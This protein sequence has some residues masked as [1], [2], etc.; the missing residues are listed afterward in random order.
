MITNGFVLGAVNRPNAA[1]RRMA[2]IKQAVQGTEAISKLTAALN[3]PAPLVR[4]AA[5]RELATIGKPAK[6]ALIQ[7]L[8]NSDILVRRI[9]TTALGRFSGPT[10]IKHLGAMLNDPSPLVR[11]RAVYSLISI[12][13]RTAKI[14][15]L[16]K[17]ARSDSS[18]IVRQQARAAT[19]QWRK[20]TRSLRQRPEFKDHPL[21]V[22]ARIPLPIDGWRFHTDPHGKGYPGK[23]F[24][25]DFNDSH[26]KTIHIAQDWEKQG[27]AGYDGVAWYR[28]TFMLPAKPKCVGADMDFGGVD[29]SAW[30]W[31]NGKFVGLHNL[32]KA[33]WNKPFAVDVS[34][35]LNWGGKNQITVRVLDRA[36]AGGIW[37]PITIVALAQ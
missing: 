27:F 3:D 28:R 37:K 31:V 6:A 23:W 14:K 32:G 11:Q 2:V 30:V 5:V 8:G 26:W 22:V 21:H 15:A 33:G 29:E 34:E 16:L 13:P 25:P 35:A 18:A 1:Q 17:K 36:M 10:I 20:K 24:E 9:A 7:A 4:R 19:A 12:Q